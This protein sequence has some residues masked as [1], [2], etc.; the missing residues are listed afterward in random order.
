MNRLGL[1]EAQGQDMVLNVVFGWFARGLNAPKDANVEILWFLHRY[2]DLR[3][4]PLNQEHPSLMI[5]SYEPEGKP[6]RW[7]IPA[8]QR[9]NT[10]QLAHTRGHW[11][12]TK[13]VM[14]V[15]SKFIWP[16]WRA[17]VSTYIH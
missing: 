13:T 1:S 4:N 12:I 16:G 9:D 8:S 2:K 17:K 14:A 10:I 6:Q 15:E 3:L 11:G 7:V 5:L